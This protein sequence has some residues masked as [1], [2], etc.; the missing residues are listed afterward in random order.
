MRFAVF[1]VFCVC[2]A[3]I[4]AQNIQEKTCSSS[5][6]RAIIQNGSPA[7]IGGLISMHNSGT[8]GYGCGSIATGMIILIVDN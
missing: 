6:Q 8:G 2:L 4:Q 7:M 5:R 1:A 3:A